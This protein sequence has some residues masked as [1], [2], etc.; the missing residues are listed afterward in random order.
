M[1]YVNDN[2]GNDEI[3]E[4]SVGL[5]RFSLMLFPVLSFVTGKILLGS[6]E[7]GVRWQWVGIILLC[8][9][10]FIGLVRSWR[11]W[12]SQFAITNQRIFMKE[13]SRIP[14]VMPLAEITDITVDQ[15]LRGRLFGYGTVIVGKTG[16]V[17]RQF[18]Y[19]SKPFEF[20]RHLL[21]NVEIMHTGAGLNQARL[22]A[23]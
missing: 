6:P 18:R 4:F 23:S 8:S 20:K 11:I 2:L 15:G 14:F 21:D 19:V 1:S 5:N 13:S 16:G 7:L 3:I 9:G 12:K 10:L 22:V 17:A